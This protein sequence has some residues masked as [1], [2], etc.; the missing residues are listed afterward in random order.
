MATNR[1]RSQKK[2]CVSVPQ[3]HCI[4]KRI[5]EKLASHGKVESTDSWSNYLKDMNLSRQI[6][7]VCTT[8]YT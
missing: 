4:K 1:N 5:T 8:Q 3:Q 2:N 6:L 7:P